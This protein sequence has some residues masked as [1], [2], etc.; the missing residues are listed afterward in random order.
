MQRLPQTS[1]Y[2]YSRVVTLQIDVHH[3]GET[4]PTRHTLSIHGPHMVPDHTYLTW[5]AYSNLLRDA[6][7]FGRITL[8]L[9]KIAPNTI[10]STLAARSVGP[11]LV[12]LPS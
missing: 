7:R 1:D 10:H 12:S 4:R 3:A 9:R 8:L 6:D 11:Y 2:S 5:S